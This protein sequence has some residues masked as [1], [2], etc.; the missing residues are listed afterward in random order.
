MHSVCDQF[1]FAFWFVPNDFHSHVQLWGS[2]TTSS[3]A[4]TCAPVISSLV[5]LPSLGNF[6]TMVLDHSVLSPVPQP[7][8][9]RLVVESICCW[10]KISHTFFYTFG[11]QQGS[12]LWSSL[13][14]FSSKYDR[15]S[16]RASI[17]NADSGGFHGVF[18]PPL[19]L[20]T[21]LEFLQSSWSP[22]LLWL[23]CWRLRFLLKLQRF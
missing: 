4:S 14:S 5:P 8:N 2:N 16:S 1:S 23:Y 15:S 18:N 6:R 9:I 20:T 13:M 17:A 19:F 12:Q 22:P 11:R 3:F 21:G 7:T 10:T